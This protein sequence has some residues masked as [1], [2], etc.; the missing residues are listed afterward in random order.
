MLF[1]KCFLLYFK[2]NCLSQIQCGIVCDGLYKT[3]NLNLFNYNG[4]YFTDEGF[5]NS[6]PFPDEWIEIFDQGATRI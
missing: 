2:S 6:N 3:K 5:Y 4:I 1:R